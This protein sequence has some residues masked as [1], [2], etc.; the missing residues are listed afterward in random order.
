MTWKYAIILV[1]K[2]GDEE[3]CELV[4]LHSNSAFKKANISSI[5]DLFLAYQDVEKDG[6]NRDFYNSGTFRREYNCDSLE[7]TLMWKKFDQYDINDIDELYTIFG[8]D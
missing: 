3:V 6:I 2:D 8:G 7:W 1:S 4:E 5:E